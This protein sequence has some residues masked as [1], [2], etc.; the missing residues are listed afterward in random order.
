MISL[1]RFDVMFL[2]GR[3]SSSHQE[4][5]CHD[6]FRLTYTFRLV[7][8]LECAAAMAAVLFY[9]HTILA[10]HAKNAQGSVLRHLYPKMRLPYM[11]C[12]LLRVYLRQLG[13]TSHWQR[14]RPWLV[15]YVSEH[16]LIS[17]FFFKSMVL[18]WCDI[19]FIG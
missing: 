12:L 1:E 18:I 19:R 3:S 7:T 10:S 4:D 15:A 8:S 13:Q 11:H 6:P 17:S 2:L 16:F 5:F 9:H 14:R